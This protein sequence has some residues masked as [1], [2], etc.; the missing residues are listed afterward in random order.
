MDEVIAVAT[1]T[2][3][4]DLE[5]DLRCAC[6]ALLHEGSPT[7]AV[8][9]LRHAFGVADMII[10]NAPEEQRRGWCRAHGYLD[11]LKRLT[12]WAGEVGDATASAE[13]QWRLDGYRRH[14][15]GGD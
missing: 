14:E 5:Y 4:R 6:A 8:A 7:D 12:A 2:R 3:L 9:Q 1:A 15:A 11:A 10:T 13:A